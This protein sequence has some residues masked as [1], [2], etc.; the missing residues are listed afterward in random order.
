MPFEYLK[1]DASDASFL[2]WGEDAE[3]LF[4]AAWEAALGLM[5]EINSNEEG[6]E[7][8]AS[9]LGDAVDAHRD[10]LGIDL[11]A[12][13]FDRFTVWRDDSL[14]KARVVLDA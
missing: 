9:L 14:L 8:H 2:A 1:D 6:Y 12:V 13:T 4:V 11:K 10:E 7:L 3:A 5:I